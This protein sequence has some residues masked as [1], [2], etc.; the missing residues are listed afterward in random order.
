MSSSDFYR[1][2]AAS[3][4]DMA[5]VAD[6]E[7]MAQLYGQMAIECLAKAQELDATYDKILGQLVKMISEPQKWVIRESSG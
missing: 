5:H 4:A 7:A 6:N 2:R 3:F 1:D